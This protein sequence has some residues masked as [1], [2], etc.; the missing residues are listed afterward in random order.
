MG[1]PGRPHRV[2]AGMAEVA[3]TIEGLQRAITAAEPAA[4][5]VAPRLLRR[6]IRAMG[7][8]SF[9]GLSVP[10]SQCLAIGGAAALR[11]IEPEELGL[12]PNADPPDVVYLLARPD[13]DELAEL[14]PGHG[15]IDAWRRLFHA[16][17]HAELE[18]RLP[19]RGANLLGRI[20][21]IGEVEFEEIRAVLRRE[22]MILPPADDRAIFIEFAAVYLELRHFRDVLLP[23]YF[24][25]LRV[26]ARIDALLAEN[27]DADALFRRTRPVGAPD[28]SPFR[29]SDTQAR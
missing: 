21:R 24:P 1:D 8:R 16:R 7:A 29:V 14:P 28:P 26:L 11:V 17:V 22:D 15:L 12:N 25:A 2:E 20:R 4:F 9:V 3:V 5:L 19:A 6:V 27:V 23:D 10:H 18:R 13:P